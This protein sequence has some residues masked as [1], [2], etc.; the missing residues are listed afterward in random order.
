M[1]LN[2]DRR[3]G[4]WASAVALLAA[5]LG[6][7]AGLN[8]GLSIIAALGLGFVLVT[9]AS[10]AAGV[11]LFTLLTFFEL[12]PAAGGLPPSSSDFYWPSPGS[13]S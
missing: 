4:L 12:I 8:P 6:L 11:V 10:L 7:L 1:A 3:Q 9:F 13:P 5:L 2:I